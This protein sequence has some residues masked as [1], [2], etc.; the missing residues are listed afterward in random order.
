MVTAHFMVTLRAEILMKTEL[1]VGLCTLGYMQEYST[2]VRWA[3]DTKSQW[4]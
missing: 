2:E 4:T 1:D 3:T